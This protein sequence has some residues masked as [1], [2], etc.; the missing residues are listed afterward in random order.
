ME[1]HK[2]QAVTPISIVIPAIY[3]ITTLDRMFPELYGGAM[4]IIKN[5]SETL[6]NRLVWLTAKKDQAGIADKLANE[7]EVDEIYGLGDAGLFDEFFYFLRFATIEVADITMAKEVIEQAITNLGEHARIVSI[8]IDRG[9]MD[10][11][12]LWWLNREGIIYLFYKYT[13]V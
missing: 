13:I 4:D 6:F 8:A 12:L 11:K 5:A 10:G 1:L 7:Q 2:G 3:E 9:F